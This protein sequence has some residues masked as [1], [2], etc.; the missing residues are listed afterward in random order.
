MPDASGKLR[1]N[2]EAYTY[3]V[4]TPSFIKTVIDK[5]RLERGFYWRHNLTIEG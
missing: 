4:N 2:K 5:P 1:W 3:E